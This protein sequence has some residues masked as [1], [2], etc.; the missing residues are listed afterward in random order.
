[1][2]AAGRR[3][4][5]DRRGV[6]AL[7]AGITLGALLVPLL[8]GLVGVGQALLLQY[9]VDR[10]THM[11]LLYAWGAGSAATAAQVQSAAQAGY[12]TGTGSGTAM[13]P[14]ASLACYCMDQTG[15]RA[16]SN[17]T[18][19]SCTATCSVSG[20]VLAKWVTLTS[21]AS[22]TPVLVGAWTGGAWTISST[23]T[24]RVQ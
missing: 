14:T 23:S 10:A 17:T 2:I 16:S 8:A 18:P 5:H 13:T 24:V 3:L 9:R 15:T 1:M 20:Q 6:A 11:G 7:E 4:L 19:A 22:F 21:S 12:G